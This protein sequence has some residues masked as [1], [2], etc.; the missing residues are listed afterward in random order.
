MAWWGGFL[1]E[2]RRAVHACL[3]RGVPSTAPISRFARACGLVAG[4]ASVSACGAFL[5]IDDGIP[6][7]EAGAVDVPM[8]ADAGV[9]AALPE[10]TPDRLDEPAIDARDEVDS[11]TPVDAEAG[12]DDAT[13]ADA[14]VVTTIDAGDAGCTPDPNWCN[15]H[16][17]TGPDNCNQMRQCPS[18]CPQGDVCS[19]NNLCECQAAAGFCTNRCG[20]VKDSCGV[21]EQCG[22]CDGAA[23][24]SNVCGC[25]PQPDS[26][27]CNNQQCGQA[28][29]NCNLWVPCGVNGTNA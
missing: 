6:F 10:A 5:N 22:D 23:C 25:A 13:D 29:N 12:G 14:D 18:D 11:A 28:M 16:C 8:S 3:R 27:T 15:T 4:V 26:V 2:C 1:R 20:A 7:D 19:A 24:T 21:V 17:N 9:E